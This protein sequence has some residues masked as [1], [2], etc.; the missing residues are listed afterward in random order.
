MTGTSVGR[1][2]LFVVLLMSTL[3]LSAGILNQHGYFSVPYTVNPPPEDA[4]AE[5]GRGISAMEKVEMPDCT[6]HVG[7]RNYVVTRDRDWITAPIPDPRKIKWRL[8]P[9]EEGFCIDLSFA[10]QIDRMTFEPSAVVMTIDGVRCALIGT[11]RL[12]Y[13][14]NAPILERIGWEDV[15]EAAIELKNGESVAFRLCFDGQRPDP[16]RNIELILGVA[17]HHPDN[18]AILPIKFCP[19]RYKQAKT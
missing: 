18:S 15:Q 3:H 16:R 1:T 5:H 14:E 8:P 7:L 19:R 12:T 9:D 4:R 11:S 6:L 10:L 13:D 2:I 17:L